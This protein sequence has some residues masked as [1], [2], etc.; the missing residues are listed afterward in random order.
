MGDP[1]GLSPLAASPVEHHDHSLYNLASRLIDVGV[2][3]FSLSTLK[4]RL[5]FHFLARVAAVKD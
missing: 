4:A 2:D 3:E 1:L 5:K